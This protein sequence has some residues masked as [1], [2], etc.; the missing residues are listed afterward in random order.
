[1]DVLLL[2]LLHA[3]YLPVLVPGRVLRASGFDLVLVVGVRRNW[4]GGGLGGLVV[5]A[6]VTAGVV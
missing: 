5:K 1:M 6:S 4:R 3:L 2:P